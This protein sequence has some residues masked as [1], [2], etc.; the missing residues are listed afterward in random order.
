MSI[1]NVTSSQFCLYLLKI[2][3]FTYTFAHIHTEAHT[4]KHTC[5]LSTQEE[6]R[7]P[8][9]GPWLRGAE[10]RLLLETRKGLAHTKKKKGKFFY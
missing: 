3:L 2:D 10:E 8:G 1:L 4:H 6:W 7:Q 5:I 9:T